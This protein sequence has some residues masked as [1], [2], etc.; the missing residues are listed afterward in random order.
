ILGA[1]LVGLAISVRR[2]RHV[3]HGFLL[4]MFLFW[5]VP[6]SLIGGK[7]LRYTLSLM[8]FVYMLSAVGVIAL[9]R[10][11]HTRFTASR[12][13]SIAISAVAVVLFV[14]VPA[15]TAFAH[16]PHYALYT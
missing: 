9:V 7:W 10:W 2:P 6:Y 8:P 1:F 12:Q 14:C 16:A 3:G 4:F 5:I 13:A 15:W 11:A